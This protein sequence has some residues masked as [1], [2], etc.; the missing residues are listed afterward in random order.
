M[1]ECTYRAT[2]SSA[3]SVKIGEPPFSHDTLSELDKL[4]KRRGFSLGISRWVESIC[5]D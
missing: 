3:T 2:L 1:T 4:H 5:L